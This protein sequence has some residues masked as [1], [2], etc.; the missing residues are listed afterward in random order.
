MHQNNHQFH[1]GVH[2]LN[3]HDALVNVLE[4]VKELADSGDIP[5]LKDWTEYGQICAALA[6]AKGNQ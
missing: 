4:R 3:S 1:L 5:N 6:R 2:L